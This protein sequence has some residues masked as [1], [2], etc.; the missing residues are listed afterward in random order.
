MSNVPLNSLDYAQP[1]QVLR[2][3]S[4][5]GAR[6]CFGLSIL[7]VSI[8]IAILIAY[9]MTAID[10]LVGAGLFW[11]M[12]GGLLT[13][14]CLITSIVMLAITKRGALNAAEGRAIYGRTLLVCVLS[15]C[16]AFL[17]VVLGARWAEG[18]HF[19][20]R[21]YNDTSVS[22]DRVIVHFAGGDI[23][24]DGVPPGAS[25]SSGLN[26]F[27][28]PGDVRVTLEAAGLQ[29][30]YRDRVFDSKVHLQQPYFD[31]HI[32]PVELPRSLR[33]ADP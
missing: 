5:K 3:V 8:G 4:L 27:G 24:L 22:L 7:S 13:S 18:P 6:A 1:A 12:G 28:A 11:L 19:R 26:W 15:Y 21:V 30:T 31:V 33:P 25:V 20:L 32:E 17:C 16:A 23:S 2:P 10:D 9:R 14:V 29:R